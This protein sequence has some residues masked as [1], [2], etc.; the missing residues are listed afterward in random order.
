MMFLII[1]PYKWTALDKGDQVSLENISIPSELLLPQ[2]TGPNKEQ[3]LVT[4]WF[5]E[6]IQVKMGGMVLTDNFFNQLPKSLLPVTCQVT[7]NWVDCSFL[8]N[9]WI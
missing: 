4:V 7:L 8:Y 3:G 5:F 2:R 1:W 6:W 9:G